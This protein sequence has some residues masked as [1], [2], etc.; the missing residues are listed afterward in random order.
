MRPHAQHRQAGERIARFRPRLLSTSPLRPVTQLIH[1]GTASRHDEIVEF[2]RSLSRAERRSQL[3][4]AAAVLQEPRLLFVGRR[5]ALSPES[6]AAQRSTLVVE[7]RSIPVRLLE[8]TNVP[9]RDDLVRA[10]GERDLLRRRQFD[11][12][13]ARAT[14]VRRQNETAVLFGNR[15]P[16]ATPLVEI[17]RRFF[18]ELSKR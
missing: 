1:D 8:A 11:G 4:V 16:E 10:T 17:S 18:E 3:D 5:Q 7:S 12:G 13:S 14:R 2:H 6:P 9:E 15:I